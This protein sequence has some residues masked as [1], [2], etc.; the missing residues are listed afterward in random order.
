MANAFAVHSLAMPLVSANFY[1]T[2]VWTIDWVLSHS[3]LTPTDDWCLHN[4][5]RLDW[6]L[7]GCLVCRNAGHLVQAYG[8]VSVFRLSCFASVL[9]FQA[10]GI[11]RGLFLPLSA[12]AHCEWGS[13]GPG[14]WLLP[15]RFHH[16]LQ[17]SILHFFA[18]ATSC[19]SIHLSM[20][21]TVAPNLGYCKQCCYECC[22]SRLFFN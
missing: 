3:R 15:T 9:R 19:L 22:T 4:G 1:V 6:T 20:D 10:P 17:L 2:A 8:S 11:P 13:P 21:I 18:C 16:L 12:L 5:E 7:P 14:R